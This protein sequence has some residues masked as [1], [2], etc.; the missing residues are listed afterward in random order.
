MC[1]GTYQDEREVALR[2]RED[3]LCALD[4]IHHRLH[5]NTDFAEEFQNHHLV[6]LVVFDKQDTLVFLAQACRQFR[7]HL[8]LVV[9][10]LLSAIL[11]TICAHFATPLG[12]E[13]DCKARG[14][15]GLENEQ[16]AGV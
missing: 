6:D 14:L 11:V 9:G 8:F 15:E 5:W 10:D 7:K 3:F 2:F 13:D 16:H 1:C 4:T 12:I